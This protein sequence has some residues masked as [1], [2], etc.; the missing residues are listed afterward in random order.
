VKR[1][2]RRGRG[3]HFPPKVSGETYLFVISAVTFFIFESEDDVRD[4]G[5]DLSSRKVLQR[6][7]GDLRSVAVEKEK[8]P[9]TA[10][11]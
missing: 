4:P 8:P 6:M 2:Y 3:G 10:G 9:A 11:A 1:I 5:T 7:R